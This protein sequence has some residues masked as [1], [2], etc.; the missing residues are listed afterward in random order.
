M[1]DMTVSMNSDTKLDIEEDSYGLTASDPLFYSKSNIAHLS[2]SMR[3]FTA[4]NF[5]Q[6]DLIELEDDE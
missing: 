1:Q 3:D 5:H 2:R 4:G 6:H